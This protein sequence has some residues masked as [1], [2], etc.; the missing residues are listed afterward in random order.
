MKRKLGRI[1]SLI[2]AVTFAMGLAPLTAFAEDYY[3]L[4]IGGTQVTSATAGDVLGDGTVS[5][6][7]ETNTLS[8][9][10]ATIT[11]ESTGTAEKD[12]PGIY[13]NGG[14]VLNV[15]LCGATSTVTGRARGGYNDA[16]G[17]YALGGMNFN[18]TGTLNVTGGSQTGDGDSKGLYVAGN[19]TVGEGNTINAAGG[20]SANDDSY[21]IYVYADS[22]DSDNEKDRSTFTLN[23]GIINAASGA[24]PSDSY[25]IY[26]AGDLVVNSGTLTGTIT[27]NASYSYGLRAAHLTMNGGTVNG[28]SEGVTSS[29]AYGV[30]VSGILT[31]NDGTINAVTG[32][33]TYENKA[34]YANELYTY[35]GTVTATSGTSDRKS[36]G[37]FVYRI[38]QICGGT[39]TA[40][41]G[42]ALEDSYGI[43]QE[44]EMN[45]ADVFR[46]QNAVVTATSGAC[47]ESDSQYGHYHYSLAV[48]RGDGWNSG[49]PQIYIY[50][51]SAVFISYGEGEYARAIQYEYNLAFDETTCVTAASTSPDGSN[52][53]NYDAESHYTYKFL[54]TGKLY[55]LRVAGI[56]I[57][58]ENYAD[59]LGDGTVSYNP[60][61]AT[62]T[63]DNANVV[64]PEPTQS[65]H[66]S[67][68]ISAVYYTDS[69]TPFTINV[70]SSSTL[71]G[72]DDEHIAYGIYSTAPLTINLA[73]G[74]VFDVNSG[75][76]AG[77]EDTAIK[78]N[79][80]AGPV[81][82]NGAGTLN[83]R[84]VKTCA[85]DGYGIY[86]T[87]GLTL[88]GG[89]TVNAYAPNLQ[90]PSGYGGGD[91]SVGV[92]TGQKPIVIGDECT[93]NAYGGDSYRSDNIGAGWVTSEIYL[94]GTATAYCKG[95]DDAYYSEGARVEAWYSGYGET[96]TNHREFNI[97][98]TDWTGTLTF[99]GKRGALYTRYS[100]D[101]AVVYDNEKINML[102]Y[103]YSDSDEPTLLSNAS[104]NV[105]SELN[106][107]YQKIVFKHKHQWGDDSVCTICGKTNMAD[108][109]VTEIPDQIYDGNEIEPEFTV[110]FGDSFLEKDVDY[111]VKYKNNV[112]CGTATAMIT[113][114]GAY[115]ETKSVTFKIK[116][117]EEA[118]A[119]IDD[120]R[121]ASIATVARINYV[122]DPELYTPSSYSRYKNAYDSFISYMFVENNQDSLEYIRAYRS[123]VTRYYM[124]LVYR[125]D[126]KTATVEK[127]DAVNYTGKAFTPEPVVK[128]GDSYLIRGYDYTVS[129]KN[130]TNA[131]TATVTI[132][133]IGNYTGTTSTTFKINKI[134]NP[135][136]AK[137]KKSSFTV[138]LSKVK[139]AA[140]TVATPIT[141]SKAQGTVTYKKSS[142]SANIT[143]DS[144][145]GKLTI[146]KG[147]AKGTYTIK[148]QVKA[149]GNTNYNA[150]T[151]TVT[152]KVVVK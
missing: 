140:Q 97:N 151:K 36:Y 106:G 42:D 125:T 78:C 61:T 53:V 129:Y 64:V 110:K 136:T 6:N 146:K 47:G 43:Y 104:Y 148:V 66:Y 72:R 54:R 22:W 9:N 83:A 92:W 142:G 48:Q 5:Y 138:S 56:Q 107:N 105:Y 73:D 130:N 49:Y 101:L 51:S 103:Q 52:P 14:A 70:L 150:L 114:I 145:T 90:P 37:I 8:L 102:G 111:T 152:L 46:I 39:I 81:T 13:Y 121:D 93:L 75:Q 29:N 1:L 80:S 30:M 134:A 84:G 25:G 143:V 69:S 100:S 127:I 141:V 108:A 109:V 74:V 71:T 98:T 10:G 15:D 34:L 55:R 38:L 77:N 32:P 88:S 113:G 45:S 65:N 122:V 117:S 57:N 19:L 41:G 18:G 126:I 118:N 135:M 59:I 3:Q 95:T 124:A 99:E 86:A 20:S 79:T 133:G 27:S 139:S 16:N 87:G 68:L 132:T 40:N 82:V 119:E 21:G 35:K 26:C 91:Y 24:A 17:F 4:W 31:L 60:A 44:Q 7:A 116:M 76:N 115:D 96:Y 63:L 2:L 131:G 28:T 137:A 128:V 58:E 23:G 11:N 123:Y 144:K 120:L 147:T 67:N 85:W 112:R 62:L 149:A 50:N 89:V 94:T 12:Y 33:A